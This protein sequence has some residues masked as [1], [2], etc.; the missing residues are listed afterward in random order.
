MYDLLETDEE[1]NLYQEG[2]AVLAY[3][4]MA[5]EDLQGGKPDWNYLVWNIR[6][7]GRVMYRFG[8]DYQNKN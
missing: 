8:Y 2:H 4:D 5:L 7:A 3:I 1:H 6:K